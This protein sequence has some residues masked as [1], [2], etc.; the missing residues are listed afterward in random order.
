MMLPD[1]ETHYVNKAHIDAKIAMAMGG[2]CAEEII[3]GDASAG[4]TSDLK[5][6]TELARRMITE[7]GMSEALGPMYLGGD[8]EVFLGRDFAQNR[9]Y[10]EKVAAMVDQEMRRVLEQGHQRAESILRANMDK[11]HALAAALI[12]KEKV[13]GEE[14]KKIMQSTGDDK[15]EA[16]EAAP[17]TADAEKDSI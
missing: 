5:H 17:E 1:E 10:S 6:A 2:R 8:H 4:A 15:G 3:M 14:F 7:F 12:E 11:L 13:D 16:T 9:N